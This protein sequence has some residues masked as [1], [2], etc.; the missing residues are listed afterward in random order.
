[1]GTF[2]VEV[3]VEVGDIE[4][5]RFQRIQALVDTG[6]TYMRVP[7]NILQTLGVP[8]QERR[9]F[10]VADGRQVEYELGQA[11]VRLAGRTLVNLVM[12][13]EE[14]SVPLLGAVTLELFGLGVDPVRQRLVP[15]VGLMM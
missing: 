4:G 3:E 11:Q 9:P 1:M 14:D 10:E 12:F 15:V 7:R 8:P 2:E 6:S 5:R 13:G